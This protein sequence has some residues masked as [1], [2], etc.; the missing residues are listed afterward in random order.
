[1]SSGGNYNCRS[2]NSFMAEH[3]PCFLTIFGVVS[4]YIS[5][6]LH[7]KD[8]YEKVGKQLTSIYSKLQSSYHEIQESTTEDLKHELK[9]IE[10]LIEEFHE[11]SMTKQICFSDWY[12]HYKFFVQM[13]IDWIDEQ[14]QF[15]FFKD[16]V[17]LSFMSTILAV[18]MIGLF[19]IFQNYEWFSEVWQQLAK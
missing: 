9:D 17:P 3:V 14:K 7:T 16:K 13:Q 12:A 18:L 6:Y 10:K 5:F 19:C 1:M 11:I 8:D 4:L 15:K 2:S